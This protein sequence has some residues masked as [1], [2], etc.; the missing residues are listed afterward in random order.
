MNKIKILILAIITLFGIENAG[1]QAVKVYKK[2]GTSLIV[3]YSRLDKIITRTQPVEW[4]DLGLPSG[5]LW[6]TENVGADYPEDYG[7]FFAWGETSPKDTYDMGNS[8][9]YG[10][11]V[12]DFSGNY[13]YDAATAAMGVSARTPTMIE[14]LELTNCCTVEEVTVHGVKGWKYTGIN[15]NSIFL[16]L[17]GV[18]NG[19]YYIMSGTLSYYMG[20]TP[21]EGRND[22]GYMNMIGD[23]SVTSLFDR[24]IGV[25]VRPVSGVNM[26]LGDATGISDTSADIPV[27]FAH[28]PSGGV[29]AGIEYSVG[30]D[31]KK[32]YADVKA[33]GTMTIKIEGLET[34]TAYQYRA[35]AEWNG[36]NLFSHSKEFK[37]KLPL[38]MPEGMEWVDLG[39]PSGIKWASVNIGARTPGQ[40]GAYFAWGELD[41]KE[42]YI[43]ENSLLSEKDLLDFSGNDEYDAAAANWGA[44]SRMP[45]QAEFEELSK[46]CLHEWITLNGIKCIKLTGPNGK[47]ITLPIA[48]EKF[49]YNTIHVGEMGYYW[50]STPA[51]LT[52]SDPDNNQAACQLFH[53][54]ITSAD[55]NTTIPYFRLTGLPIRPVSGVNMQLGDATNIEGMSADIPVTFAHVP[56]DGVKAGIEYSIGEEVKKVYADV[57]ADGEVIIKLENLADETTYQYRAF[58]EWNGGFI[59]SQSK[60]FTT[61]YSQWVDL[62]L[63]SGTKWAKFNVGATAPEQYGDYFAWGE[64]TTKEAYLSSNSLTTNMQLPDI[65]GNAQYDAATSIWGSSAR[66][67]TKEEMDEL[68]N[69]CTFNDI[70]VNG[71]AGKQVIGPNGRS[72]FLPYAGE[73]D[74]ELI[75]TGFMFKYWTSTPAENNLYN[76]Y[77]LEYDLNETSVHPY[78][79]DMGYPIRPVYKP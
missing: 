73:Y 66:M 60:E 72:I 12:P 58:T 46:N 52:F 36:V 51:S 67:P 44:A 69:N 23:L 55:K 17:A 54:E 15:G 47:S 2:D 16:P 68:I 53:N 62:G 38:K 6:A 45:T 34:E 30:K 28:V 63:P 65:S 57:K 77:L 71:I 11:D 39:L 1:A 40:Y 75:H 50:T 48:G 76:A 78:Y 74:V 35:F 20:S 21:D 70:T 8:L 3:P 41:T 4:V 59:Y 22:V 14:L 5:I 24:S 56:S 33:D 13:V 31:V 37:T 26:Q 61:K 29:K 32:V 9:N 25:S 10:K 42:E 18:R 19:D 79:R 64:I 49:S 43:F 7:S 27:T